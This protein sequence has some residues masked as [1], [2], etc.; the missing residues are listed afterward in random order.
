VQTIDG[1][2]GTSQHGKTDNPKKIYVQ[3]HERIIIRH[4]LSS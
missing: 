2:L 3:L 1:S 4:A